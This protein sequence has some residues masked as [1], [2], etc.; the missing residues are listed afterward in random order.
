MITWMIPHVH[1]VIANMYLEIMN[2]CFT[3]L[4]P[5]LG[6]LRFYE[7]FSQWGAQFITNGLSTTEIVVEGMSAG[8]Y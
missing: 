7:T 8:S 3:K 5:T 6:V 1:E 2:F 4:Y